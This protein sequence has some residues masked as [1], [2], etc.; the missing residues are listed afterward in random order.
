MRRAPSRINVRGARAQRLVVAAAN[1]GD[2]V[3]NGEPHRRM[4]FEYM[5]DPIS[6]E[7]VKVG[8]RLADDSNVQSTRLRQVRWVPVRSLHPGGANAA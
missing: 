2:R 3:I 6:G 1:N 8:Q 5:E 7:R 4:V